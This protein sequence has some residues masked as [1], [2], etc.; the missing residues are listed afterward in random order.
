MKTTSVAIDLMLGTRSVFSM[1]DDSLK[2]SN[3]VAFCPKS[4]KEAFC[5]TSDGT[6]NS[7][8]LDL[9]NKSIKKEFESKMKDLEL[10]N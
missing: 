10:M 9:E 6:F 4:K 2:S 3:L 7:Y 1:G 8:K 5:F